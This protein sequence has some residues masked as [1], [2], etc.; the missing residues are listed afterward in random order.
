MDWKKLSDLLNDLDLKK[1]RRYLSKEFQAYGLMLASELNDWKNR[2]LYIKLA[3]E[4]PREW[5]EK[6]RYFVKDQSP[7]KVKNKAALFMWKLNQI[8]NENKTPKSRSSSSHQS[9]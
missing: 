8:K 1:R 6:A 5:L 9:R 7:G 4:L 2:S 3:K